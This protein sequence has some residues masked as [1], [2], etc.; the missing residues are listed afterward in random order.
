MDDTPLVGWLIWMGGGRGTALLPQATC[1][2][3]DSFSQNC[4]RIRQSCS[5]IE[6]RFVLEPIEA[7]RW[8]AFTQLYRIQKDSLQNQKPHRLSF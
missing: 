2:P 6:R 3:A 4:Y 8:E 7:V 5:I 1:L